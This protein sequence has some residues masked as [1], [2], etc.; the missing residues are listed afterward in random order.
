MNNLSNTLDISYDL[1]SIE[2]IQINVKLKG[3]ILEYNSENYIIT[4]HRYYPIQT[5]KIEDL[6]YVEKSDIQQSS[7]NE[8]LI[9][10]NT[11]DDSN[12]NKIKNVKNVL[13][14]INQ[15][16]YCDDNKLIV[17][18][19]CYN[20]INH[21][22]LYPRLLYI[23]VT[24][25]KINCAG[26]PVFQKDGKLIGIISNTHC[27]N[28]YIIPTY[29]II[30]TLQKKCNNKI[31]KINNSDIT[32]IDKFNVTN[33]IVYHQLMSKKIPLDIYFTLEGDEDKTLIF[34]KNKECRYVELETIMISNERYLIKENENYVVNATLLI[35]LK[36]INNRIMDD[37]MNFVRLNFTKKILLNITKN[38]ISNDIENLSLDSSMENKIRIPIEINRKLYNFM[39]FV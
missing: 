12:Y 20:N 38:D 11:F 10:K 5:I 39:M 17:I 18:D 22:P 24:S 4:L 36:V 32:K 1:E 14:Y 27:G 21:L 31:F 16:L 13:P 23:K 30:K 37:F 8:L 2:D 15:E 34:N 6:Y 19:Y 33:N 9:I 26:M 3:F 35:T 7:W 25:N 29:Y 28:T